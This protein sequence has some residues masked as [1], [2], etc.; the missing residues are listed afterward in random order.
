MRVWLV[1]VWLVP[2]IITIGG[3][4]TIDGATSRVS[5]R[6]P[7]AQQPAGV[8]LPK[9]IRKAIDDRWHGWELAKLDSQALACRHD[10]SG[11]PAVVQGDLDDDGRPDSALLIK[12]AQGVRLVA[13]LTRVDEVLLFE[14]DSLGNAASDGFLKLEPQGAKFSTPDGLVEDYF[15][16]DTLTVSRCAGPRVAYFW[17][18]LGFDKIEIPDAVSGGLAQDR[19]EIDRL[20]RPQRGP[21]ISD[22]PESSR[23]GAN[24]EVLRVEAPFNLLPRQR[25]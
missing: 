16:A 23:R 4:A 7:A 8:A 2:S 10:A 21:Q 24:R 17:T 25:R 20:S 11:S 5:D 9:D 19:F 3:A 22:V 14:V 6:A 15:P 18:G 12:T 13:A 1:A